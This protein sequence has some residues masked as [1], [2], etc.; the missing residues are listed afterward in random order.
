MPSRDD[1]TRHDCRDKAHGQ[2][3]QRVLAD[4]GVA[5]RRVCEDLITQGRVE[6]NGVIIDFLPAFADPAADRIRVDG[7]AINPSR[8]HLYVMLNKPTRTVTTNADEPEFDRRTV[9]DLV[10]HPAADRLFPIGRLDYDTTGLLLLTNDGELANRLTHPRFGVA[11]T[12]HAVVKG[13]LTDEDARQLQSGID[14]AERKAGRAAGAA[15]FAR[16]SVTVHKHDRG[17]TVLELR[18]TEGRNRQVRRLLTAVGCPVKKLDRVGFGPLKLTG[19]P[20]GAWRELTRPEIDALR[21]SV[22]RAKTQAV[23]ASETPPPLAKP[24]AKPSAKPGA[25]PGTAPRAA[26]RAKPRA[27][28]DAPP[29]PRDTIDPV[30]LRRAVANADRPK[31]NAATRARAPR[32]DSGGGPR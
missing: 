27:G 31:I 11:K 4:A 16:V 23:A 6:V 32:R 24:G 26:S 22:A 1:Q 28:L 7:R 12:Y 2:R 17:R 21:R 18:L 13:R 14:Q 8:R 5:A 20:T 3:L 29:E 10:D 25:K 30:R 19:L 9:L 15:R